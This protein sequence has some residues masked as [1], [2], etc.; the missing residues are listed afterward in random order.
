MGPASKD[1]WI[2]IVA[3]VLAASPFLFGLMRAFS[4]R[5]D[6]R[7]LWMAFAAFLGAG[8]VMATGKLRGRRPTFVIAR[9]A[10]ALAIAT[11]L[12]TATA[13][14]LGATA[15]PG[16]VAVSFVLSLGSTAGLALALSDPRTS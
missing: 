13:V 15:A 3:I 12:A 14:Q 10:A 8:A 1:R 4:S 5:H 7:M 11:L 2:H 9:S 16:I 6:F